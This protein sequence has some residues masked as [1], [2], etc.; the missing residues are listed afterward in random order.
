VAI[1]HVYGSE[2]IDYGQVHKKYAEPFV[3]RSGYVPARLIGITLRVVYGTPIKDDISTS[4]V[5][6]QNLTMRMGM[7]RMTRLT[8]GWSKK[9][10][11]LVA[12]VNLHFYHYNFMRQHSSIGS[13][14]A[15]AAG[16]A[17]DVWGWDRLI[18]A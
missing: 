16:I 10:E 6:R 1:R 15:M 12:A 11:N 3:G 17:N 2:A 14:P 5:E 13:T 9:L 4:Y 8:N 18:S 7:R